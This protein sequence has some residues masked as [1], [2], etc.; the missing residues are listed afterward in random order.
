MT[1]PSRHRLKDTAFPNSLMIHSKMSAIKEI[2]VVNGWSSENLKLV[3]YLESMQNS[4]NCGRSE[5]VRY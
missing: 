1:K 4:H 2:V 5:S 3:S